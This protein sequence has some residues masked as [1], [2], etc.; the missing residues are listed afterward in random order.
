MDS[1]KLKNKVTVKKILTVGANKLRNVSNSVLSRME[2]N[3]A[4]EDVEGVLRDHPPIFIIG[5]PR[6]GSTLVHQVLI[7]YFDVGY[8]SNMHCAFWGTPSW[9]QRFTH[10]SPQQPRS[11]FRSDYGKTKGLA[12]PN[13]C[14]EYWYRFFR[15]K[16]QYVPMNEADPKKMKDMRK[17]IA[18]LTKSFGRSIMFKNLMNSVRLE[19]IIGVLPEARFIVIKRDEIA[20]AHSILEARKKV[21]GSYDK[22]FSLEPPHVTTY[23]KRPGHEQVIEQIR[24]IYTYI[25]DCANKL[26]Q[27][28]FITLDYKR[29]CLDTHGELKKLEAF[30]TA[31]QIHL[32]RRSEVPAT[33]PFTE[34]TES[35]IR[36]ENSIFQALVKYANH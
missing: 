7:E 6:C 19:P 32:G 16:P 33:F 4:S 9:V 29:V 13:E 23:S 22:W 21:L 25:D 8:L 14:G 15:R 30:F 18:I 3:F 34:I 20:I 11:D 36:I 2:T 35:K 26:G 24:D 28:R 1:A 31:N 5:A 17:A 27:H 12:A 10:L